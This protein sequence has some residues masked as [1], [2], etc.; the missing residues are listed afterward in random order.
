[1]DLAELERTV[2]SSLTAFSQS[3]TDLIA[4]QE[5]KAVSNARN[6][7]REFA[8]STRIDQIDLSDL[9]DKLGTDESAAL[10]KTLRSAVKYN[11]I[12]NISNA[13]GLSVYFPYQ[14]VNKVDQAVSTYEAIGMDSSYA[15]AIRAF[16]SVEASGQAVSG[17]GSVIPSLFGGYGGS[18]SSSSSADMISDLLNAFLGGGSG[19]DFLSGRN[20]TDAQLQTYLA[21]NYLDESQL[22]FRQENGNWVLSL[23][24]EQWELVTGADL[25]VFYDNGKGYVDL[26]LDNVFEFDDQGRMVADVSG[27]WLAV[28]NQPVA[29]YR[30]DSV[31]ESETSWRISGRVPAL[32]NG[33][34]VDLLLVFD[35]DHENGYVAGA[36]SV[37]LNGETDT[38][39]KEM[40]EI[41]A[42]DTLVFLA[43]LYDYS[44]QYQANYPLG[45]QVTVG[46]GG[47]TVSDVYLPDASK[48][49]FT[50]RFTDLYQQPHWVPVR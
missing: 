14:R 18:S 48:A 11:R 26:G 8:S 46:K 15:D 33:N 22:K 47:L 45:N 24:K 42:G 4:N 39:A 35:A 6:G 30:E 50:Y 1:M 5:Y 17:G 40:T 20:L 9:C 7:C 44:Q 12:N 32:L 10:A 37:Y 38:V 41:Q 49:V 3:V 29:Y 25:N 34:R 21:A 27:T 36:R 28:N 43:D 13:Y 16:A 31:Y 2:P 19:L 23:P